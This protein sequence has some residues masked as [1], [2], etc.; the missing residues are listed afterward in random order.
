MTRFNNRPAFSLPPLL[1]SL[2]KPVPHSCAGLI[3]GGILW[4]HPC[5]TPA[6]IYPVP[7][8]THPERRPELVEGRRVSRP[9]GRR[10]SPAPAG[11]CPGEPEGFQRLVRRSYRLQGKACFHSLHIRQT[12]TSF[13]NPPPRQVPGSSML[14]LD[15][16]PRRHQSTLT[17]IDQVP[18]PHHGTH[19][20]LVA[21][22]L[23]PLEVRKQPRPGLHHPL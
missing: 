2:S 3:R 20:A 18:I 14:D 11:A 5:G 4:G 6:G 12:S 8:G 22:Q 15:G 9:A 19:P 21:G 10:R 23:S 13:Q 1:C 16:H 17:M 7:A